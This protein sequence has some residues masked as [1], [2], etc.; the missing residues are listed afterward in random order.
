MLFE[1]IPGVWDFL[2][3]E[4]PRVENTGSGLDLPP[5]A[6]ED[7][8]SF[9]PV[10]LFEIFAIIQ[11]ESFPRLFYALVRRRQSADPLDFAN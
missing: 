5:L 3:C 6:P 2:Y 8:A 11:I 7:S 1:I 10:I 9:G 4:Q